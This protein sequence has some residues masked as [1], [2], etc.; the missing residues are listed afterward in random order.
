MPQQLDLFAGPGVRDAPG[1]AA[2]PAARLPALGTLDDEAAIDALLSSNLAET[3]AL[4]QEVGRRQLCAAVPA[5]ERL[6]RRFVGFGVAR[7]V[8]E[9]VAALEAL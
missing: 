5:L 8:P 3:L 6:C 9:Q 7:P 1:V 4:A 2:K